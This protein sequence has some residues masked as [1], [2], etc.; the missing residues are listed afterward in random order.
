MNKIKNILLCGLGGLG[1]ICASKITNCKDL[2]LKI[3]VDKK[4]YEKY[5]NEPT[6]FNNIPYKF[7]F[8]LPENTEFKADLVIISTKND[9]LNFAINN[10]KHFVHKDTIFLSLLN[11][12]LSEEQIA[13]VYGWKNTLIS[14]YIGHSCIRDGRNITQ[15]G[16]YKFV[17]GRK[18]CNTKEQA[19]N[20]IKLLFE[21]AQIQHEISEHI[22]DEYWKKFM[23][24]VG[25][26]QLSAITGLTLSEIKK[27]DSLTQ[28]LKGLMKEVENIAQAAGIQN[29]YKIY[30]EAEYFLLTEMQD[31]TPSMLQDIQAGRKTEVDIFAGTIIDLGKK[32]EIKTPLNQEIYAKIKEIENKTTISY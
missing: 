16:I 2:E 30:K 6:F 31:A 24:N 20:K 22:M 8:I 1:S 27:N 25:I 18:N 4:R 11:G 12:I 5:N 3:L 17:I 32:Y 23:I 21:E 15:D 7:N 14:F 19:L 9:G 28:K 29:H 10:I 26:N 13:S